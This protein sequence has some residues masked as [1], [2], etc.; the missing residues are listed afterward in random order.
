MKIVVASDG[1]QPNPVYCGALLAAGA[2]P[3]EISLVLPGDPLPD[4]FDG[5]LLAGGND[6]APARYGEATLSPTVDVYPERDTL[7]FDL[8]ARAL[9]LEVPVLGICRGLQLLNVALGGTLWQDLPSQ[10]DHGIPHA[11]YVEDGFLPG[12]LVHPVRPCGPS[13]SPGPLGALLGGAGVID[14]NSRHHQAV[15]D[16][17][18]GLVPAALSPD[19]LVEA[20]EAV[21]PVN[22][23]A[24]QWHPEDLVAS[25]VQRGIF[26]QLVREA[27]ARRGGGAAISSGRGAD[28]ASEGRPIG[29]GAA[30]SA[31]EAG[32]PA[33]PIP[34]VENQ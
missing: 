10:R 2:G 11:R 27:R 5:L 7:D 6:V 25:P 19:G 16:L 14:V 1:R 30:F 26:V 33:P 18:P 4:R 20:F 13:E 32:A 17:A 31:Q 34:P 28:L 3:S 23:A 21:W 9:A 22:L 15:K 29:T 12:L 8:L 24:V